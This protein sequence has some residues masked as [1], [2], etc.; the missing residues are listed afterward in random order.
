M[1]QGKFRGCMHPRD[2]FMKHPIASL[3][4]EYTKNSYKVDYGKNWSKE[5]IEAAINEAHTSK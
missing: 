1:V 3:L 5:H 4:L 2:I